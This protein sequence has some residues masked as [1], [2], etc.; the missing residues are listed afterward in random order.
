[1]RV[2]ESLVAVTKHIYCRRNTNDIGWLVQN[3][4]DHRAAHLGSGSYEQKSH[5]TVKA[6]KIIERYSRFAG[7]AWWFPFQFFP[8]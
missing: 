4:S 6:S 1:M 3:S 5:R 7:I 8:T 2:S